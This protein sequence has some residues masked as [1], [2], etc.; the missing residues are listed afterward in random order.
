[1]GRHRPGHQELSPATR[2]GVLQR[3]DLAQNLQRLR[4]YRTERRP[5]REGLIVHWLV[6]RLLSWLPSRQRGGPR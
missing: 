4:Q 3:C 5:L 6:H 1:M 2:V